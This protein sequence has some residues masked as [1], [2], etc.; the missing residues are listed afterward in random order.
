MNFFKFP[1][2]NLRFRWYSTYGESKLALQS[3]FVHQMLTIWTIRLL[4]LFMQCFHNGI[5]FWVL[6][7][8]WSVFTVADW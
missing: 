6:N 7:Y 5:E 2:G 8:I 1:G 4:H 3:R